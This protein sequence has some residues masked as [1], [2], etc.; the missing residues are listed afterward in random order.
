MYNNYLMV[1]FKK[2]KHKIKGIFG[3]FLTIMKVSFICMYEIHA[4]TVF[5]KDNMHTFM[6]YLH[7]ICRKYKL[8]FSNKNFK[9]KYYYKF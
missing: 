1:H 6:R 5:T 8:F 2:Y 9:D 4:K 7:K 3:F